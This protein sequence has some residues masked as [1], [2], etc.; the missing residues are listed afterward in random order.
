M[1]PIVP[2]AVACV[3]ITLLLTATIACSLS[4]RSGLPTGGMKP[5][6]HSGTHG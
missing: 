3:V 5:V 2:H 1:L 4:A 6:A